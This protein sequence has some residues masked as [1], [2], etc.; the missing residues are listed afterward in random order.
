MSNQWESWAL[1]CKN[2][3][4][5]IVSGWDNYEELLLIATR[6]TEEIWEQCRY[7]DRLTLAPAFAKHAGE[8][9]HVLLSVKMLCAGRNPYHEDLTQQGWMEVAD[10][11]TGRYYPWAVEHATMW[12]IN[13]G[14]LVRDLVT[15]SVKITGNRPPP[16]EIMMDVPH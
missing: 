3:Y 16:R 1:E 11:E 2:V 15:G 12:A 5:S 9:R 6:Q 4:P 7:T 8:V 13:L 10:A 14:Y